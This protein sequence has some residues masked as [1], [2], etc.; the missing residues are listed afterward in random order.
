MVKRP[1]LFSA[2]MVRAIL[3]GTKTQTRRVISRPLK[4]PGWTAYRYFGPS[5]NNPKCISRAIE[6]G[7]DY[8]DDK[9]DQVLCPF[10][11]AGDLLWV[12]EAF[13]HQYRDNIEPTC[14]SPEDVAYRADGLTPDPYVYGHWKPSI[15]MPR[16]ASRIT[17]EVTGIRV[18]KLQDI[19]EADSIAEGVERVGDRFKGY[20]PLVTGEHYDPALAKTSY[21]QLWESINGL[22]SWKADPWVWVVE[23]KRLPS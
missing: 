5:T 6:C 19:S 16:W 13:A 12:R 18:E 21:S 23:F 11:Q 4:N 15:H 2:P 10:G 22:G 3:A 1:I 7:P 17:L 8:P 9:T 20:L 14:R